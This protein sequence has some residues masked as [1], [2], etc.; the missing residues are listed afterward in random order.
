[1]RELGV[2]SLVSDDGRRFVVPAPQRYRGGACRVEPDASAA[3]YFWAAA[4]VTGGRVAVRG[5]SRNSRQGDVGFADILAQMGCAVQQTDDGLEV[6]GPPSG[7]LH[8][9]RVDLNA[10]P[11]T[12]QTLAVAALFAEGPTQI[13]NVAN[14]RIKET[15]RIA[16]LASELS[17]LGA[18]VEARADGLTIHPPT[19]LTPAEI[20]TYD[21]HR[22]AMSFAVA[23]LGV[24]GLTIRD[25]QVVSKSFPG[26]FEQWDRLTPTA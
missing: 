1:M 18:R 7:R 25:P 6:T 9:V 8:G 24:V 22:M 10:M 14:L 23:G 16:A 17:K 20:Q 26:F 5:L 13:E 21:D 19:R 2:E 11:D 15:D 12:A 4:A 3:T